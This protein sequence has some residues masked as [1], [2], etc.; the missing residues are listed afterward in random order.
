[1]DPSVSKL[2]SNNKVKLYS[3]LD[4]TRFILDIVEK[5]QPKGHWEVVN[6]PNRYLQKEVV[7]KELD[8]LDRA[9]T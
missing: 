4:D 8:N 5:E 2:N 3:R 6:G 9:R 7:D 1:M